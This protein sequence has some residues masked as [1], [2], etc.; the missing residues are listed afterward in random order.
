M[1]PSQATAVEAA[2]GTEDE[3]VESA[4][5]T[6]DSVPKAV[7]V[8]SSMENSSAFLVSVTPRLVKKQAGAT[9]D[10]PSAS[11]SEIT[12]DRLIGSR[13]LHSETSGEDEASLAT[14]VRRNKDNV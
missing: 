9:C 10:T 14:D 8:A 13:V 2:S 11:K 5:Q 4:M 3:P 6:P 7:V 1:F 12:V